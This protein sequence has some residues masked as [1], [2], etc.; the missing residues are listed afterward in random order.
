MFHSFK[1]DDTIDSTL[2][3]TEGASVD[4]LAIDIQDQ[5]PAAT[6]I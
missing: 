5:R 6:T 3:R 4:T 2:Q 1:R